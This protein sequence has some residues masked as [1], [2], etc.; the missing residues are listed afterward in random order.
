MSS[1]LCETHKPA[2]LDLKTN[3]LLK[4]Q[5]EEAA[6]LSGVNLTAFILNAASEKARDIV[7]FNSHTVLSESGWSSLNEVLKNP[8]QEATPALKALM[9]RRKKNNGTTI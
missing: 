4:S 1:A 5:L 8:P 6:A 2:R 3:Q 9:K 7:R